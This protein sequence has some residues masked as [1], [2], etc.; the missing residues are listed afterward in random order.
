MSVTR[1][2][3][4][5]ITHVTRVRCDPVHGE[6]LDPPQVRVQVR[7]LSQKERSS[8]HPAGTSTFPRRLVVGSSDQG[9]R[10][11]WLASSGAGSSAW[12]PLS[13]S[14][15]GT[16]PPGATGSTDR[17][18][19]LT[20]QTEGHC[21]DDGRGDQ[22]DGVR[23]APQPAAPPGSEQQH[24]PGRRPRRDEHRRGLSAGQPGVGHR[25]ASPTTSSTVSP[26]R[27]ASWA[28]RLEEV[29]PHGRR[30]DLHAARRPGRRAG[31]PGSAGPRPLAAWAATRR[32][33]AAGRCPGAG[34]RRVWV[35]TR[36]TTGTT[37]SRFA[38]R[39][40]SRTATLRTQAAGCSNA[41]APPHRS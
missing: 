24:S 25:S 6:Q 8:L 9:D 3:T 40:A 13:E 1:P 28:P 7:T 39:M 22:A 12:L 23:R 15:T 35:S 32:Q 27:S 17:R 37:R 10:Q 33:R 26:R 20:T 29:L 5:C 36:A 30:G 38:R 41:T 16:S 31:P 21:G 4:G 34:R 14:S 11:Q 2:F 18:E 19:S